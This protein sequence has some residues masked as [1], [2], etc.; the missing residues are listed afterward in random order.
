MSLHPI[1]AVS[2]LHLE[3]AFLEQT[4]RSA[5]ASPRCERV[6]KWCP[7][8]ELPVHPATAGNVPFP[9]APQDL[10][11]RKHGDGLDD[12]LDIDAMWLDLGV[13]D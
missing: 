3:Q 7:F 2:G 4:V 11:P 10:D 5:N 1:S 6:E 12:D 9:P 13:G 8:D